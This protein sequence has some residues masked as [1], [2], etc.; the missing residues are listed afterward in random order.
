MPTP[1][2]STFNLPTFVVAAVGAVS[3]LAAAAWNVVPYVSA[4][5]KISVKIEYIL[6]ATETGVERAFEVK[7]N[8]KRRGSVEI[9]QWG[10]ATYGPASG[11]YPSVVYLTADTDNSDKV[12]ITILGKH[13]AAWTVYARK[14]PAFKWNRKNK[15]KVKGI[16]ELGDGKRTKSKPLLLQSGALYEGLRVEA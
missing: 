14:T 16:V 12:P 1:P 5:A 2:P 15:I 10:I 3:G 9:R 13:G 4:G 7:A 11:R 6:V 8:N